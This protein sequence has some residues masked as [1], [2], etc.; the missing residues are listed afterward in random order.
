MFVIM[1]FLWRAFG[2]LDERTTPSASTFH[3]QCPA[4]WPVSGDQKRNGRMEKCR[5]GVADGREGEDAEDEEERHV[6][7]TSDVVAW[8]FQQIE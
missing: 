4:P 2:R 1:L 7:L 3:E 6:G 5:R 8:C